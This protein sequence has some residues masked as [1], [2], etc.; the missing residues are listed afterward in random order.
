MGKTIH[1][2]TLSE[3]LITFKALDQ[4]QG[5]P[6]HT[7]HYFYTHN[8]STIAISNPSLIHNAIITLKYMKIL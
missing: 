1:L 2:E 8:Q 3:Q 5:N 6:K 7:I 4:A